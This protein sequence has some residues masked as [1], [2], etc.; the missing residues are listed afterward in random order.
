M[1][2]SIADSFNHIN[3]IWNNQQRRIVWFLIS[4]SRQILKISI[5]PIVA[6]AFV[7]L[8]TFFRQI[9]LGFS[10]VPQH[11]LF[12]L[13]LASLFDSCKMSGCFKSIAEIYSAIYQTCC[14]APFSY[15]RALIADLSPT[16]SSEY[17]KAVLRAEFDVLRVINFELSYELPFSYFDGI[18]NSLRSFIPVQD[19]SHKRDLAHSDICFIICSARY[20]DVPPEVIAV[21]AALD[22]LDKYAPEQTSKIYLSLREKYG[23]QVFEVAQQSMDFEKSQT[24]RRRRPT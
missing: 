11:D 1:S 19:F 2:Q 16:I 20:L 17:I 15:T 18:L 8:Q 14:R 5:D 9:Q 24:C 13:M 22:T 21:V 10:G 3:G 7:I 6:S 12:T 4:S 23:Q